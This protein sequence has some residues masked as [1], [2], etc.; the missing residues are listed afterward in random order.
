MAG[1]P[2]ANLIFRETLQSTGH[3]ETTQV[4][5]IAGVAH[6]TYYKNGIDAISVGRRFRRSLAT[7]GRMEEEL[8][9]RYLRGMRDT[10]LLYA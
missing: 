10:Y 1:R 3:A 9:P 2:E 5:I 4:N 8:W 7:D 6:T